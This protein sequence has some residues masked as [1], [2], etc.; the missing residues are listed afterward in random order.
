M[1]EASS[2]GHLKPSIGALRGVQKA[3]NGAAGTIR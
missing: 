3:C 1:V 2:V